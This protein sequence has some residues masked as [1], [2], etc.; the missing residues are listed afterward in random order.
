LLTTDLRTI[1][2]RQQTLRATVDWSYEL[3]DEA[4]RQMLRAL[5]VFAGGWSLDAVEGVCDGG[6]RDEGRV[7]MTI[8]R[9]S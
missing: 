6:T 1:V 2:P 4:E 8:T 7:E 5:A 3:L 9:P